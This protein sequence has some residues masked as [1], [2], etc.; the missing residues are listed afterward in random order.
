MDSHVTCRLA[1]FVLI[2]GTASLS[3]TGCDAGPFQ[4]VG[5]FERGPLDGGGSAPPTITLEGSWQRTLVFFDDFGFLHSS[6]TTWTFE[7]G[8]EAVRTVVAT[9][10]TLGAA[11]TLVTLAEWRLEGT[12]LVI[13]FIAPTPGTIT[14]SFALQGS[15]LFLAGQEYRRIA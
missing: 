15:T 10:V 14:L 2:L 9:N 8:G 13:E 6:E 7:R 12:N 5:R 4:P 3:T 11:D 1:A